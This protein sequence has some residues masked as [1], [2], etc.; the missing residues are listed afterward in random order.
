MDAIKSL[1]RNIQAWFIFPAFLGLVLFTDPL[2]AQYIHPKK[3]MVFTQVIAGP[4]FDSVI[5]LTNRGTTAYSGA[6][7]LSTGPEGSPWN[8]LVNN[9]PVYNGNLQI[10][11][12]PDSTKIF[13]IS[14]GAFTVGIAFI[15]SFDFYV[16][17]HVEGNLTYYSRNGSACLDAV[18]VPSSGEFFNVSLPF[19]NFQDVGLSLGNVTAHDATVRVTLYDQDD[20]IYSRCEFPVLSGGHFA[21]YLKELPWNDPVAAFGPVGKVDIL[22]DRSLAGIAMTVTP[23]GSGGAQISTLPL[24]AS[25]LIYTLGLTAHAGDDI[26]MGKLELWIDGY[27]VKGY[28]VFT[29]INGEFVDQ[30]IPGPLPFL[31]SGRLRDGSLDLA[32]VTDT[33]PTATPGTGVSLYLHFIGFSPAVDEIYGDW[34][35]DHVFNPEIGT[36]TGDAIINNLKLQ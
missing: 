8:P 10:S 30:T 15:S 20:E 6:I 17:N 33:W 32:F 31:V 4:G 7:F 29:Q 13:T 14:S 11:I 26:Y 12:P 27:F 21:Q 22:A 25:P 16:T 1:A 28:M 19:G 5:A 36:L 35:A 2:E 18:G 23:D 34:R 3:E 24:D 9:L